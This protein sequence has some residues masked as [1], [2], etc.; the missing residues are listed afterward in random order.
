VWLHIKV[1]LYIVLFEYNI[2][3]DICNLYCINCIYCK[4]LYK[5]SR[6]NSSSIFFC[7]FLCKNAR[8]I[9]FGVFFVIFYVKMSELSVS[10]F[11]FAI[12]YVKMPELSVSVFFCDFYVKMP[13][14][15]FGV[16][17]WFIYCIWLERC[18]ISGN[19]ISCYHYIILMN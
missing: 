19:F 13:E 11:F 16:F 8:T 18:T 12:F 6:T 10:A 5:S 17:L 3:I 14:I 4:F 1:R 15:S 2:F 9:S 7:D